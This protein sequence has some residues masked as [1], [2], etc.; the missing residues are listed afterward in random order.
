M[1][2][3]LMDGV[4]LFPLT[5]SCLQEGR[6]VPEV[7]VIILHCNCCTY[8]ISMQ[9]RIV[10]NTVDS[11]LMHNVIVPFPSSAEDRKNIIKT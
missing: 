10:H 3:I 4:G 2:A 8:S 7:K 6:V 9:W 11:H 1:S 5:C